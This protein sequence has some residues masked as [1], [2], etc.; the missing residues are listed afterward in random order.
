M[1]KSAAEEISQW[2]DQCRRWA[3]DASSREQRLMLQNLEKLLSQAA[4]EADETIE[5][6]CAFRP[7]ASTKA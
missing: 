4:L 7:M 6:D 1:F 5:A 3:R 2:A